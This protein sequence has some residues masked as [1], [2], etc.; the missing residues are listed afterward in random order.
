M[1]PLQIQIDAGLLG[2]S[3][4][5]PESH[6]RP[7]EPA[8]Q[9]RTCRRNHGKTEERGED[10]LEK[11]EAHDCRSERQ[12]KLLPVVYEEI[13][14]C[15]EHAFIASEKGNTAGVL[16]RSPVKKKHF[17]IWLSD[18]GSYRGVAGRKSYYSRSAHDSS[19][20]SEE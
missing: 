3:I 1:I 14:D 18:C 7:D 13:L 2:Q 17:G 10:E 12:E 11:E 6:P 19:D 8:D 5:F 20:G 15:L 9:D 16:N 4:D